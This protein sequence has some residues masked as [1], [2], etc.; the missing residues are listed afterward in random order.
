MSQTPGNGQ[1]QQ[2]IYQQAPG[3]GL[4]VTG[5]V[6]GIIG[7]VFFWTVWMGILLG[8]LAIIFGAIGASKPVKRGMGIAGIVLG[9][10]AFVLGLWPLIVGAAILGSL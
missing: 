2:V 8:I 7:L 4:A 3:N 9:I 6:L 10:L 5:L 1:P